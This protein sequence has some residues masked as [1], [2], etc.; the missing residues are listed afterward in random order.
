MPKVNPETLNNRG[1]A[2]ENLKRFNEAL[3]SYDRAIAIAPQ[4]PDAFYK[5]GVLL[6]KLNRMGEAAGAYQHVLSL[7]PNY[8]YA[9]GRLVHTKMR[10]CDWSGLEGGH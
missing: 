5:R 3:A 9:L 7:D 2:L 10:A 4:Q 6:E 8:K 1:T